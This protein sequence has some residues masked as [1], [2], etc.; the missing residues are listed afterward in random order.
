MTTVG[1]TREA[2][3]RTVAPE[4]PGA[5][6]AR[7]LFTQSGQQVALLQEA[8]R[9]EGAVYTLT[10]DVVDPGVPY[11]CVAIVKASDRGNPIVRQFNVVRGT[12]ISL[13]GRVF[14]VTVIDTT[15]ATLPLSE[16]PVNTPGA[17]TSYW[18]TVVI[19][20]YP[21]APDILGPILYGGVAIIEASSALT[22]DIPADVGATAL[23]VVGV[24]AV[25]LDPTLLSITYTTAAGGVFKLYNP[26]L[27]PGFISIPPSATQVQISNNDDTNAVT[28]TLTWKIDG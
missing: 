22:V 16:G 19:E 15:P 5:S 10:F 4:F 11:E 20:P 25:P 8:M 21:R 3:A 26:V 24:S 13:T 12:S 9:A 18:I 27:N 14:Q 1:G 2:E 17:G 28:V 7:E 23:E 6:G